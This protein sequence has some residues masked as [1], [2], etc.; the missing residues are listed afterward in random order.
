MQLLG[1]SF[2]CFFSLLLDTESKIK[3]SIFLHLL[4][5]NFIFFCLFVSYPCP[6]P[7]CSTWP[8]F[9]L[10]QRTFALLDAVTRP[11]VSLML[12]TRTAVNAPRFVP[13]DT[14]P[15]V[16]V[17]GRIMSTT[18]LE[19]WHLVEHSAALGYCTKGY[20]V[21]YIYLCFFFYFFCVIISFLF[22]ASPRWKSI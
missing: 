18:A 22:G 5:F 13:C 12:M 11:S 19:V 6:S 10:E 3:L 15:C 2:F 17:T 4:V 1:F 20:A 21:S 9:Y 7:Y 8:E 14:I 16:V